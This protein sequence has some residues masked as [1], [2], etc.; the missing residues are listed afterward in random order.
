M[1]SWPYAVLIG[2]CG[3]FLGMFVVALCA[4]AKCADCKIIGQMWGMGK[5]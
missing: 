1:I 4:I 3:F 2:F 5:P